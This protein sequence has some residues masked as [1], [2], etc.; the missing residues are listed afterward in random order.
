[1]VALLKK[2]LRQTWRSFRL[3]A[4]YLTL[5]FLAVMDPLTTRYMG[6]IIGKFA[7]GITIT[8]PP[9]SA[10]QAVGS[11]VGDIVEIGVLV[12][13]A[14][15]MGSVAG[16]RAAGVTT[17]VV[18]KPVSKRSYILA[19][20]SVLGVGIALGITVSVLLAYLYTWSLIGPLPLS[21]VLLAAVSVGLYAHLI[22][23][24]TFAASMV[25][26][27]TLAAGGAGLA[28]MIL[29]GIAGAVLGKS[30]IG[31]YLPSSL[32]GNASLFLSGAVDRAAGG[33]G[34]GGILRGVAGGGTMG[35]GAVA[36]L[37]KPGLTAVL[38]SVALLVAAFAR[39]KKQPLQ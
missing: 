35:G 10:E 32:M 13:I 14:I 37:L 9:P 33:P 25:L 26:P 5:L 22:M 27:G 12:I 34:A 6:E 36:L 21:R 30:T 31:P 28:A 4:F 16:E 23:V 19:K 39:F 38:L 11:F 1:V 29:L 24:A 7:Q 8:V 20:L 2:E 15:T 18:T 3:P 17:F